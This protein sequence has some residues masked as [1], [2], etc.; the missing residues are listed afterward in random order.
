MKAKTTSTAS[1]TAME[2]G[3]FADGE[4]AMMKAKRPDLSQ[5]GEPAPVATKVQVEQ[6]LGQLKKALAE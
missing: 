2:E 5:V 1:I 3:R 4:S 6:M